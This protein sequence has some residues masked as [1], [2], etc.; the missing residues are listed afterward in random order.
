M[1]KLQEHSY[2][3]K[4]WSKIILILKFGNFL[5]AVKFSVI[6]NL[7]GQITATGI[8]SKLFFFFQNF[9]QNIRRDQLRWQNSIFLEKVMD[10]LLNKFPQFTFDGDSSSE[11]FRSHFIGQ[12]PFWLERLHMDSLEKQS[13][14][15]WVVKTGV[16]KGFQ[17][18]FVK[19]LNHL[20]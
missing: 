20:F 5:P 4:N 3:E 1:K 16:G 6:K 2:S 8:Q 7:Q 11:V 9:T 14:S 12:L 17:N 15:T 10:L 19:K 13:E 18:K